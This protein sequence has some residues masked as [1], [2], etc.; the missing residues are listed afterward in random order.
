VLSWLRL[1]RVYQ[2]VSRAAGECVRRSG[3]TLAQF[4]VLAQVG[5]CEGRSQQALADRLLVT[6]GNVTQILDRM[7]ACGLLVRRQ[8]GRTKTV[9]LTDKGRRLRDCVVPAMEATIRD[10]LRSLTEAEQRTLLVLLR[11]VDRDL[12]ARADGSASD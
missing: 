8:V 12:E 9:C 7:E 6:K 10:Q 11:T 2:Q 5:A 1:V 3:L 4:D